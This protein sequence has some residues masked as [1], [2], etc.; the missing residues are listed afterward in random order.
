MKRLLFAVLFYLIAPFLFAQSYLP[1]ASVSLI[2]G[3][4]NKAIPAVETNI[5][6]NLL[7]GVRRNTPVSSSLITRARKG[8]VQIS[9]PHWEHGQLSHSSSVYA[10]GFLL[11]YKKKLYVA[12]AYHVM[13]G[14]GSQR[15]VRMPTKTGGEKEV[16]V[17]VE[18]NGRAG[19]H[20]PD[21]SLAPISPEDIPEGMEPL[22][23]AEP[24]LD[25]PAYSIGYMTGDFSLED[26]LPVQRTFTD[27]TENSLYG[28]Y[29]ID[30]SSSSVPVTGNGQ[31]GSPIF[32]YFPGQAE[33]WK[34]VGLHN[35]HLLDWNDP[36]K[37][38]GSGVNLS[39]VLPALT[40]DNLPARPL[41]F[42]GQSV[43]KLK[44]NERVAEISVIRYGEV[45]TTK[46]MKIFSHP[47]ED[48]HAE[49]ALWNEKLV[50]GDMIK[51]TIIL[52]Q[53]VE[54]KRVKREVFSF[55]Q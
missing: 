41:V 16:L 24:M 26:F 14:K 43:T 29:H 31:C 7:S 30:G 36:S 44:P 17:E 13:G 4:S 42:R 50:P 38:L 12:S 52:R 34:V 47:Y 51:F 20:E 35:G 33:E 45:V 18:V 53:D 9:R 10:S 49:M 23:V 22:T 1:R 19:W 40:A 25:Q 21:I 55:V 37:S 3:V 15:V 11:R 54:P 46:Q 32:Q 8:I 28:A 48:A 39:K 27:A 6:R 5:A 2:K